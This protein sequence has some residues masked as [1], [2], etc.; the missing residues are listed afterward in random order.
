MDEVLELIEGPDM[1]KIASIF[2]FT[3]KKFA[4]FEKKSL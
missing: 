2:A 4:N 3:Q 1:K